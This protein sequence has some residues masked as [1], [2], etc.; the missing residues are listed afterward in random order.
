MSP[1]AHNTTQTARVARPPKINLGLFV[2][3]A[4]S[5]DGRHE[6]ASVM[7][8]ISL[9]DELTLRV[10]RVA[11]ERADRGRDRLPRRARRSRENLAAAALRLFRE[12]T[13]WDA[14][15]AAA[16][17]RQAHPGGRRPGRRLGRRGGGAA[18]GPAAS[19]LGSDELLLELAR[20]GWART[21]PR[22]SLPGAGWP[23]GAGERLR[24]LPAPSHPFGV[25]VLPVAAELSTAA[26][27]AQ[28]DG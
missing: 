13:G 21:C 9:A 2:G 11:A 17:H 22:R 5:A 15:A 16:E 25:L 10:H 26:V 20:A 6:L 8:S 3:P 12:A 28:A 4:A 1:A 7:Q 24:E 14:G 19:G 27:Y 18:P 23:R